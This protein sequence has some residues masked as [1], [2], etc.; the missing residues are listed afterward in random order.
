MEVTTGDKRGIRVT[1]NPPKEVVLHNQPKTIFK[2]IYI[3]A[4]IAI[5]QK[6]K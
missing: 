1:Q 4:E 6:V 2:T 3:V 5:V